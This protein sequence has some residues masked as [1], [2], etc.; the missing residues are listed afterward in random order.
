MNHPSGLPTPSVAC[1]ARDLPTSEPTRSDGDPSGGVGGGADLPPR[2]PLAL[3][4][5]IEGRDGTALICRAKL[6]RGS[7]QPWQSSN[8]V[9]GHDL[10]HGRMIDDDDSTD[11]WMGLAPDQ[12]RYGTKDSRGAH[13]RRETSGSSPQADGSDVRLARQ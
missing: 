10:L 12:L 5:L 8:G 2:L 9:V 1:P 4:A 6:R 3:R 13:Q 7:R 11:E